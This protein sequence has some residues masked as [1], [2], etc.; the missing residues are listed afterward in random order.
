M[1]HALK[2]TI[3]TFA[4]II[5]RWDIYL[6]IY[7]LFFQFTLLSFFLSLFCVCLLSFFHSNDWSSPYR[8]KR[9]WF[10]TTLPRSNK[11]VIRIIN[12]D[13]SSGFTM[14]RI[15]Y[16]WLNT[17]QMICVSPAL[18]FSLSFCVYRLKCLF[19]YKMYKLFHSLGLSR[20]SVR[21]CEKKVL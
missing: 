16:Y 1:R 21:M 2:Y 18:Y 14:R 9:K 7:F 17:F 13:M 6:L 15:K 12:I 10:L 11:V 4:I 20:C 19:V 3:S 8:V 5:K